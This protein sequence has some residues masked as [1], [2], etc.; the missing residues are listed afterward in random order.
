MTTITVTKDEDG[1][2]G[3]FTEADKRAYARFRNRL[4]GLEIGELFTLKTWFPRNPKLHGLHF[5]VVKALFEAQEQF[6]NP[7]ELR[8]WLYVGAGYA[9]F[10]PGPTG[11]MVAIPKSIAFDKIDD[12]DFSDLHRKVVDFIRS[13]YCQQFLWPH[14][15]QAQQMEMT[16]GL[17]MGFER[18]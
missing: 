10:M 1:K 12:A 4:D 15:P 17:L 9:D 14:L 8:K 2:L 7:D 6:T 3:G 11:K 5:G 16:E 13:R 18:P